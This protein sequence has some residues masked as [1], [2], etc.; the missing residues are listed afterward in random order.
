MFVRLSETWLHKGHTEA[1][2]QIEDFTLFRCDSLRQKK[3]DKDT[4]EES[5]FMLEKRLVNHSKIVQL[6]CLYSK[7]QNLVLLVVYR[8]P[9]DRSNGHPSTADDFITPL[10]GLKLAIS[11]LETTQT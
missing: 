9:D 2:L 6:L 3:T 8:Q 4:L 11:S 10:D 7:V 1:E 5:A